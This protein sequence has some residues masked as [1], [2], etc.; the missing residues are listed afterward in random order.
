MVSGYQLKSDR[1][2]DDGS[3]DVDEDEAGMRMADDGSSA[4]DGFSYASRERH[5]CE[6]PSVSLSEPPSSAKDE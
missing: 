4:G 3:D 6:Q 1:H 2:D 5:H